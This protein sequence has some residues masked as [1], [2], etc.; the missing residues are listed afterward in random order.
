[1]DTDIL[2]EPNEE[3]GWSESFYFNF[4]DKEKDIYAFMRIGITP[5]Q[6]KNNM[7]CFIST[8]DIIA[9][10][11]GEG[12]IY[13]K[14]LEAQGLMFEKIEPEKRWKMKFNGDMKV[15]L[16]NSLEYVDV[17][18]DLEFNAINKIFDY[19]ECVS[20]QKEEISQQVAS[21][22]LEQFGR[23]TGKI[24][25][26]GKIYEIDGL[27]ERDHSWGVR[28]WNAPKMRIWLT[29]QFSE[30]LAFN[31]TKLVMEEGEVD[32]GFLHVDGEDHPIT[33]AKIDT[34]YGDDGAPK[35]FNME[36]TDKEGNV[37]NISANVLKNIV[38]PFLGEDKRSIS[39]MH[40]TLA[41]YDMDGKK[42]Y[43]IAEY[44]IKK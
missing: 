35:L 41:V 42:G 1:M 6:K 38:L 5:N 11:R 36:I 4:Y 16:C 25:A 34:Q 8:P 26:L 27:G 43:G 33:S 3:K 40:E 21:E 23:V 29:G 28:N 22:H 39:M 7:L 17:N 10:K 30:D 15:V 18:L 12:R 44:L 31:V 20:G 2:H 37:R 24:Q 13:H 32:A 19:R 9:G 14:G